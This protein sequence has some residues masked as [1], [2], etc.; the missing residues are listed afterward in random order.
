MKANMANDPP[1]F[2]PRKPRN[3]MFKC[4]KQQKSEF[5]KT[6]TITQKPELVAAKYSADIQSINIISKPLFYSYFL[7]L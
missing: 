2:L 6:S 7:T 4:E 3:S 1:V 5:Q